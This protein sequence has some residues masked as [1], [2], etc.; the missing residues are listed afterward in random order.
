METAVA[1]T[2]STLAAFRVAV[3]RVLRVVLPG[4]RVARWAA[5]ITE[6]APSDRFYSRSFE[7]DALGTARALLQL[8]DS[9]VEAGW[10][11]QAIQDGGAR[12]GAIAELEGLG[13]SVL[14]FGYADRLAR[15]AR[16][17]AG[18]RARFYVELMLAEP[19]E[20]WP[21]RWR[22]IFHALERV[23]TRL[24]RHQSSLPGSEVD[25]DLGRVQA[26]L[27][28]G[29]SAEPILLTGDGSA[30]RAGAADAAV[31]PFS[32]LFWATPG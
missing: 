2:S 27:E 17:L 16:S 5:R 13:R 10:D 29:A 32:W 20:L 24:T 3:D 8:R 15:V 22:V 18:W 11:G 4:L 7:V 14:P 31:R 23:G 19:I 26:A 6:L 30:A 12:V 9:W 28:G 21:S 1:R 25:S